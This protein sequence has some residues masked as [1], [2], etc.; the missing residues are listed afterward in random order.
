[1]ILSAEPD[2][3]IALGLKEDVRPGQLAAAARY[4][5]IEEMVYWRPVKAGEAIYSAAGTV[6]A[7][8]AGLILV[9]IQQNV[10]VT[11]RLYDYGRPRELHLEDGIAVSETGPWRGKV[12]SHDLGG[13]RTVVAQGP[14]LTIERWKGVGA[15][16]VT[17]PEDRPCWL[18]TLG[19][20]TID[21]QAAKAGETWLIDTPT[22][23][24]AGPESELLVGYEGGEDAEGLWA[25]A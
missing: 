15:G 12:E 22:P 14:K 3:T 1:M 4:G 25:A 16:T 13:G 2:S 20:M 18:V 7:I 19:E 23:I 5:S 10:D 6:H 9:E 11:Y 17:P 21:G 24:E 8:G